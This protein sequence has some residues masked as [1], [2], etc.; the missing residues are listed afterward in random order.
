MC[1]NSVTV[2][3]V[4]AD[5]RRSLPATF[6]TDQEI[7]ES[8]ELLAARQKRERGRH[9]AR[10]P[11]RIG[12][13]VAQAIHRYGYGRQSAGQ[14]LAK[15]WQEAA[16]ETIAAQTRVGRLRSGVLDVVV[17]SSIWMQELTFAR[18]EILT[19]LKKAAPDQRITDFRFRIGAIS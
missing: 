18:D 10:Q 19:R 6:M 13:A 3:F 2:N 17:A 16:G 8:F 9:F 1:R 5:G 4:F 7:A 11:K 12:E 15:A 14:A